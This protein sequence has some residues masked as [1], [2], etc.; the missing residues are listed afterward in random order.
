MDLGMLPMMG[1]NDVGGTSTKNLLH[2]VQMVRAGYFQMFD[3]GTDGNM[4]AYNQT[5]PPQYNTA[6]FATQLAGVKQM[7]FVGGN[8][9]LVQPSDYARL[10]KLLP[11]NLKSKT[12]ED[13]NHLD[14][15]WAADVNQYVNDDVREFLASL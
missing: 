1:R 4:I 3:Y 15:M 14:Y 6:N 7:H 12:I 11:A 10:V 2:W 9:A 5:Y 13:Y 8:D